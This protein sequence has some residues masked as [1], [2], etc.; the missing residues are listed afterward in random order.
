MQLTPEQSTFIKAVKESPRNL[1]CQAV[2][3]SGKTTTLIEAIKA[4]P[5]E[6]S[7]IV[8]A[9]NKSI[10]LEFQFRL[11]TDFGVECKTF[12]ALGHRAIADR[13]GSFPKLDTR[14]L[15]SIASNLVKERDLD[16]SFIPAIMK[17]VSDCQLAGYIPAVHLSNPKASPLA[18]QDHLEEVTQSYCHE[19]AMTDWQLLAGLAEAAMAEHINQTEAGLIDFS[20]QIY[21]VVCFRCRLPKYDLVFVD[22]AQ[23]LNSL[24][25]IMVER[26]LK[27]SSRLITVGD[28]RQAIYGWRGAE[29]ESMR[30]FERRFNMEVLPLTTS[31]RCGS[32]IIKAAQMEVPYIQPRA[33]AHPGKVTQLSNPSIEDMPPNS[34]VICRT[35]APLIAFAFK[36]IKAGKPPVMLGRDFHKGLQALVRNLCSRRPGNTKVSDLIVK[37]DRWQAL[38]QE[39]AAESSAKLERINDKHDALMSVIETLDDYS[40]KATKVIDKIKNLFSPEQGQIT[41]TTVHK[42]KGLEWNNV[43]ILDSFRMNP[44]RNSTQAQIREESNIRYVAITRAIDSLTY[45]CLEDFE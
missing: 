1:S 35:N 12:N 40:V 41:L 30:L 3:G 37:L 25:H 44:R 45:I 18:D 19:N 17:I 22:E 2:A 5:E 15:Y 20:D 38:E 14:K 10:Q 31:F 39:K 27:K 8:L 29:Q 42:A 4:L 21:Y 16:Y 34:V 7:K 43:Y 36:C 9:F 24:Q 26:L 28:P 13:L 23:D 6:G 33:D 11:G 32:N